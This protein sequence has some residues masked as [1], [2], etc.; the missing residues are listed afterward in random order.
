MT[1]RR[2]NRVEY[3]N[4]IRDLM[5]ID[6]KA[7]EEFPPDDTGYGFDTIGDVLT[8]SPLLLAKYMQAAEFIVARAVPTVSL[9]APERTYPGSEFHGPGGTGDADRLSFHTPVKLTRSLPIAIAGDYRIALELSVVGPHDFDASRCAASFKLDDQLLVRET[10]TWQDD[11]KYLYTFDANITPGAHKLTFEVESLTSTEDQ[12]MA[13]Y[14]RLIKVRV[15]GPLDPKHWTRPANYDRF[16]PQGEPDRSTA[17]RRQ[18]VRDILRRFATRAFRRPV[19][20]RTLDG[21]VAI[22]ERIYEQPGRRFAD[23]VARSMVAVLTSPRFL[24]RVEEAEA[25]ASGPVPAQSLLDEYAL[26]SRLSYFLWSTMPD[27]EL[28]RLAQRHELRKNLATQIER[29]R[30]DAAPGFYPEFRGSMAS[31]SRCPG[32]CHQY[33]GRASSRG[34]QR[35]D[36]SRWKFAARHEERNR[37]GFR[38]CCP[39]GSA[40]TR[41]D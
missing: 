39:R 38:P 40:D 14:I 18:Y 27:D 5:G 12:P 19:D 41:I 26:A 29:M 9:V 23:G 3:A 2:L 15:Q 22:A 37:N 16:W 34:K 31:G 20:D 25:E 1:I 33:G 30:L 11:K 4:T 32:N 28:F 13:I 6:F 21:L 8:V 36:R 7:E 35:G 24:F 10:Y 17:G